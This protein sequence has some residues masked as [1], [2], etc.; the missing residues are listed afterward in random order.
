MQT[1]KAS[2]DGAAV[3]SLFGQFNMM[4][5]WFRHNIHM[6]VLPLLANHG[7]ADYLLRIRCVRTFKM[8]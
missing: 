2:A 8:L 3:V 6:V 5:E 4:T 1:L 7:W